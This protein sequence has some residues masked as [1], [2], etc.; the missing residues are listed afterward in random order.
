MIPIPC[1]KCGKPL[2]PNRKRQRI[3][4]ECEVEL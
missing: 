2:Q 4:A 3:C 1:K